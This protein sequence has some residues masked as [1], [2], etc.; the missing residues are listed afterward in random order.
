MSEKTARACPEL[1]SNSMSKPRLTE[2]ALVIPVVVGK[3]VVGGVVGD[4]WLLVSDDRK[5]KFRQLHRDGD[6]FGVGMSAK[7]RGRR[8]YG[9]EAAGRK[10]TK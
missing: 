5:K 10:E 4:L 1:C 3:R 7:P 8:A 6:S 9:D 2:L